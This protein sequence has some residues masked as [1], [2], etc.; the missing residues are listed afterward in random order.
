MKKPK[1]K[2]LPLEEPVRADG[3]VVEQARRL[4]KALEEERG[5]T[6]SR[7]MYGGLTEE[8]AHNAFYGMLLGY[9]AEQSGSEA[10]C[11]QTVGR[12]FQRLRERDEK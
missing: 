8:Q 5:Y 11:L 12:V 6:I 1:L 3:G 10:F 9:V 2:Y 4:G 7:L